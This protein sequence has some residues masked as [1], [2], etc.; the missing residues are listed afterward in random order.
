[1]ATYT[2]QQSAGSWLVSVLRGMLSTRLKNEVLQNRN[3]TSGRVFVHGTGKLGFF[4][5]T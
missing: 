1:M 2:T 4:L 5:D 3:G